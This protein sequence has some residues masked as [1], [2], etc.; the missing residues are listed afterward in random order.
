MKENEGRRTD[1]E[2][3]GKEKIK[4]KLTDEEKD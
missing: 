4:E 2:V 3:N 1:E